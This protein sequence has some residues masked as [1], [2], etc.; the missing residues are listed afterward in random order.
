[1]S[2]VL[3]SLLGIGGAVDPVV[4]EGS[5][6]VAGADGVDTDVVG[7]LIDGHG[8]GHGVNGALGGTVGGG[9]ALTHVADEGAHVDDVA[10]GLTEVGD[11]EARDERRG[12]GRTRRG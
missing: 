5:P 2:I 9:L 4:V 12:R 7:S 6:D 10:L 8:L 1:M 3:K 11:A